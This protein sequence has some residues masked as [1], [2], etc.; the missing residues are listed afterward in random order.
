MKKLNVTDVV[1]TLLLLALGGYCLVLVGV[2]P[3][4]KQVYRVIGDGDNNISRAIYPLFDTKIEISKKEIT[5]YFSDKKI[6]S[7]KIEKVEKKENQT[8]YYYKAFGVL[9][10]ACTLEKVGNR[11]FFTERG[12]QMEL[13]EY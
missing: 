3:L 1:M 9:E 6:S 5:V 4:G 2:I 7:T 11:T 8:I 13:A 12:I 10:A